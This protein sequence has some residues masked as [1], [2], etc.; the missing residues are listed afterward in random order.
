M[1]LFFWRQPKPSLDDTPHE[2]QQ[3]TSHDDF[4]GI[5][6]FAPI[7]PGDGSAFA[8]YL[9]PADWSTVF[10]ALDILRENNFVNMEPKDFYKRAHWAWEHL[11]DQVRVE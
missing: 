5:K 6:E 11:R 1:N 7:N 8:L 3:Q 10:I 4:T 2:E 9:T